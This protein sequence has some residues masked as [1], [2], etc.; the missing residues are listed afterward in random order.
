LHQFFNND[1][2]IINTSFVTI[3][4]PWSGNPNE[5]PKLVDHSIQ[6]PDVEFQNSHQQSNACGY[7]H[8]LALIMI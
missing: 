7:F 6:R 1:L 5:Y 3:K 4:G 8:V 2:T